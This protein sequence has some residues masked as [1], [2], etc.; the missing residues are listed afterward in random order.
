VF[1]LATSSWVMSLAVNLNPFMRFDGYYLL[2]DALGLPNLQPRAFA[3]ARWKLRE[4]L[5]KLG[6]PAPESL[7]RRLHRLLIA[8]AW[9][10]WVYRL[11]LYAGIALAVYHY[12][13]KTLGIALFLVEVSWFLLRPVALE[14]QHW[15]RAREQVRHSPR[16]WASLAGLVGLLVLCVLPLDRSVSLPALLAPAQDTPLYSDVPAQIEAVLV[17]DGATVQQGEVLVRLSSPALAQQRTLT[18]TRMAVAQARLDRIAGAPRELAQTMVLSRELQ[19]QQRTLQALDEQ[20]ARLTVRAPFPGRLMDLDPDLRPGRWIDRRLEI[21]RIVSTQERDLRAYVP[22]T[23]VWR[24]R[25]GHPGRFI[26]DDPALAPIPARVVEIGSLAAEQIDLMAL[27]SVFGGAIATREDM[28]RGLHPVQAQFHVRLHPEAALSGPAS[29]NRTQQI[30]GQVH[31]DA[32]AQ[33]LL[34]LAAAQVLRVLA[35]ES[36]L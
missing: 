21:G 36:D 17:Q 10:T 14:L 11:V 9:A 6:A 23:E 19:M 20:Q 22:E 35:R 4:L 25:T 34:S 29:G 18:F 3:L 2:S 8:Y 15:W 26:P 5:L 24:L 33:S 12:F 27:S 32:Q 1:V 16:A 13:F 31:L 30:T 28:S 7:P